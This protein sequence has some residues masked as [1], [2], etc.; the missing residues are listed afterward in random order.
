MKNALFNREFPARASGVEHLPSYYGGDTRKNCMVCF[1]DNKKHVKTGVECKCCGV[2][3]CM[4]A[5][6]NCFDQWHLEMYM[7]MMVNMIMKQWAK[8]CLRCSSNG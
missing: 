1:W 4:S 2:P 7:K 8:L 6:R 3:L 5:K